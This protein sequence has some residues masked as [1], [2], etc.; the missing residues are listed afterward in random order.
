MSSIQHWKTQIAALPDVLLFGK[1]PINSKTVFHSTS[2]SF[3][4]TNLKPVIPG[5]VLVSPFRVVDRLSKLSDEE[6]QDL[7]LCAKVVG[8]AILL[9]HP[10]A[11]SL[12]V[13]VQDGASAGQTVPHVHIHVMPRWPTDKFNSGRS[14]NDA[15]YKAI[16]E[17]ET[18]MMNSDNT[19]I[20][21]LGEPRTPDEMIREGQQMRTFVEEVLSAK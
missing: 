17:S 7:F 3:A 8:K 10:H 20:D 9:A 6:T 1:F 15:V 12:T 14:G 16:D 21:T 13:T 18:D 19:R 4:F 5:H 2:K 11:D